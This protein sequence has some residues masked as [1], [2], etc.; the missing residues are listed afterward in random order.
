VPVVIQTWL[1]HQNNYRDGV[2]EII[3]CGGDTDTC[4]AILGGIIGARV[5][6][7]G[8]PANWVNDLLEW[9][10]TIQWMEALRNRL[11]QVC[12]TGQIQRPQPLLTVAIFTRNL[13]FLPIV[14]FHGFRRLLPPY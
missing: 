10:R 13:W 6:K 1:R 4:A 5:G 2:L 3:R 11:A 9:P 8:I 12:E 14:L 7:S